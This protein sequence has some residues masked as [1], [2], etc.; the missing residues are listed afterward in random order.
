MPTIVIVGILTFMRRM[1]SVLSRVEHEKSFITQGP[2]AIS[3]G[4]VFNI[5]FF[6]NLFLVNIS[7]AKYSKN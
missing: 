6:V 3:L 1:N 7:Y 5:Y 2:G 4:T